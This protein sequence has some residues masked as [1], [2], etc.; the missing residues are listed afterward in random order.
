MAAADGTRADAAADTDT[1]F[2][3]GPGVGG[4]WRRTYRA[5]SGHGGAGGGHDAITETDSH[6]HARRAFADTGCHADTCDDAGLLS[7]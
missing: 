1:A 3:P 5:T 2:P 7:G 4:T 6:R